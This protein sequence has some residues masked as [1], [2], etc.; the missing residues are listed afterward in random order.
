MLTIVYHLFFGLL[1]IAF[2]N[3]F[4]VYNDC[5]VADNIASP[6]EYF[7]VLFPDTLMEKITYETNLYCS[8]QRGGACNFIPTDVKE[9]K[10]F[11]GIN[12]L[13]GVKKM[14]SYR[15]FWSSDPM[16]RDNYIS[17]AAVN[18][19]GWL[20]SNFHI[21]DNQKMPKSGEPG[22]DKLYKI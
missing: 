19:F 18:R 13:M 1:D 7:L 4:V 22:F 8:Q 20:L 16:L 12:I 2:V 5:C 17:S 11:F 6:I 10:T 15:D 14:P 9:L 21:N 3:S